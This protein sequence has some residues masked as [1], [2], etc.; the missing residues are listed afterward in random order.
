M[1]CSLRKKGAPDPD[2]GS[3]LIKQELTQPQILIGS[4]LT[5]LSM[6]FIALTRIQMGVKGDVF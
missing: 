3:F 2:K 1:E 5:L 6:L 4:N